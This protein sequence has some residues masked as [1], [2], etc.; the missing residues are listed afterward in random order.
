MTFRLPTGGRA[1]YHI[2]KRRLSW[3]QTSPLQREQTPPSWRP[4][5]WQSAHSVHSSAANALRMTPGHLPPDASGRVHFL[6]IWSNDLPI[7]WHRGHMPTGRSR[8]VMFSSA[9][10][11]IREDRAINLDSATSDIP[12]CQPSLLTWIK[13]ARCSLPLIWQ[14][15]GHPL[16][17]SRRLPFINRPMLHSSL[18][19]ISWRRCQV[20]RIAPSTNLTGTAGA[21]G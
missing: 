13:S 18:P 2:A 16:V 15:L 9:L 14:R 10:F 7:V 19:I 6:P 20:S 21:A 3:S 5:A 11:D 8:L 4:V 17:A 12:K 1:M